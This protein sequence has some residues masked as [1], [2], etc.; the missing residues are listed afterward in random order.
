MVLVIRPNVFGA[1]KFAAGG[2]KL[3][4]FKKLKNSARKSRYLLPPSVIFLPRDASRL[5][6]FGA[7]TIPTP[8]SPKLP[9]AGMANA[10][11]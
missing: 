2:L 8:A 10:V 5:N 3:G 7:R 9:S 11:S 1:L 4:W 6:Y